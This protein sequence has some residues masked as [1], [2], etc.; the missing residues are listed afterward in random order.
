MM[1]LDEAI[2]HCEDVARQN[3]DDAIAYSNFKNHRK[4]LYEIELAE[5]AEKKCRKCAEEHRQL[6]EW[7]YELRA[8]RQI[9]EPEKVTCIT[10][11]HLRTELIQRRKIPDSICAAPIWKELNKTVPH[12]IGH[13]P[14]EPIR[15]DYHKPKGG[16][17]G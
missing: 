12:V 7:L 8:R 4:N 13:D 14:R 17:E 3:E 1:T 15:C 11:R 16:A 10:C 6:A 5:N 9:T 2:I